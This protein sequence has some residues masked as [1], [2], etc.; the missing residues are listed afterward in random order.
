MDLVLDVDWK[1]AFV[2]KY[3]QHALR[4]IVVKLEKAR[5]LR[6]QGVALGVTARRLGV[7]ERLWL[8]DSVITAR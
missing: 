7:S 8:G 1:G 4:Q 5:C 3:S 6:K 2:T